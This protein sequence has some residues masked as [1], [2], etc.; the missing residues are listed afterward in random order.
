MGTAPPFF[1]P[2][3][4]SAGGKRGVQARFSTWINLAC[5]RFAEEGE[6][7]RRRL[8]LRPGQGPREERRLTLRTLAHR[9]ERKN[10][11]ENPYA[12]PYY[13]TRTWSVTRKKKFFPPLRA[14]VPTSLKEGKGGEGEGRGGCPPNLLPA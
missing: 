8:V 10:N 11:G 14:A 12:S 13:L 1:P 6:K 9:E 4:N 5:N 3:P 2:P 7:K